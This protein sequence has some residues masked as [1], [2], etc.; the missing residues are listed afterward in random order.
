[1]RFRNTKTSYGFISQFLHWMLFL[2]I[3]G[4]LILGYLMDDIT[5]KALRSQVVNLHKL[6]GLLVLLMVILRITW[7]LINVKPSLPTAVRWE[8]WS[9]RGVHGLLYAVMVVMP[10]SGWVIASTKRPP[11]L[12][13][14]SLGL[15]LPQSPALHAAAKV[16]HYWIAIAIIVLVAVHVL[17]AFYHQFVKKENIFQRMWIRS[18]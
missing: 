9:A 2:L 6:T 3:L 7:A 10:L 16:A 1:M 11:M 14:I 15:P 18:C 5:D 4:L 13:T 8:Q 17:A 12:G